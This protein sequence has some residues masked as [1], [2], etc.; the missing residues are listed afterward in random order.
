MAL[1][2]KVMVPVEVGLSSHHRM[3]YT[4]LQNE[5][6]IKNELDLLEEK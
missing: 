1:G 4:Q 3:A 6:L 5:E 2:A